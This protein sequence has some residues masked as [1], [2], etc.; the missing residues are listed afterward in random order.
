LQANKLNY[1]ALDWEEPMAHPIL[2]QFRNPPSPADPKAVNAYNKSSLVGEEGASAISKE[3]DDRR[4]DFRNPPSRIFVSI[5]AAA[6]VLQ[7]N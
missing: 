6:I 7:I 1:C 4:C 3:K 5:S 2:L